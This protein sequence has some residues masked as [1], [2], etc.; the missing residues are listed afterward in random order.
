[1]NLKTTF[2][3]NLLT[4]EYDSKWVI[5]KRTV[6]SAYT[7]GDFNILKKPGYKIKTEK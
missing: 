6:I 5:S 3:E 1:M 2:N 7:V 4:Y